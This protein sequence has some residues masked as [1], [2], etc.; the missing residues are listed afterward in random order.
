MKNYIYCRSCV[1]KENM[2]RLRRVSIARCG[3]WM[4]DWVLYY[5]MQSIVIVF[6]FY[7][8]FGGRCKYKSW[9]IKPSFH[10]HCLLAYNKIKKLNS[11]WKKKKRKKIMRKNQ[12]TSV[13]Y[14]ND[15]NGHLHIHLHAES[16]HAYKNQI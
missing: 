2:V 6:L 5:W 4:Y 7:Y 9:N 1:W 16:T 10:R 11:L 8:F 15:F 14:T 13:N 3:K 12:R